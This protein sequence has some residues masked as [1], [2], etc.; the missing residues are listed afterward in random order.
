MSLFPRITVGPVIGRV[1]STSVRLLVETDTAAA[2]ARCVVVYNGRV[3]DQQRIHTAHTH[4]LMKHTANENG[5]YN[6]SEWGTDSAMKQQ[7]QSSSS[8]SS[9]YSEIGDRESHPHDNVPPGTVVQTLRLRIVE[10]GVPFAFTVRHL[11]PHSLYTLHIHT[12]N[13]MVVV[14]EEKPPTGRRIGNAHHHHRTATIHTYARLGGEDD[15]YLD[16]DS[17]SLS[18]AVRSAIGNN[19][20]SDRSELH[21]GDGGAMMRIVAV[22]G[23]NVR[24]RQNTDLWQ[25]LAEM[26]GAIP[27]TEDGTEADG[28]TGSQRKRQRRVDLV[29]HLGSQVFTD[30]AFAVARRLLRAHEEDC[31]QGNDDDDDDEASE[32]MEHEITE[33]FRDL[34]RTA[35]SYGPLQRVLSCA[36]HLMLL[37]EGELRSFWAENPEDMDPR[38]H[39]FYIATIA[40]RVYTEYQ[41]QLWDDTPLEQFQDHF[42]RHEGSHHHLLAGRR[43]SRIGLL[44]LDQLVGRSFCQQQRSNSEYLSEQQWQDMRRLLGPRGTFRDTDVL[45]VATSSPVV[46]LQQNRGVVL[47]EIERH[48]EVRCNW[49]FSFFREEQM[50]FLKLLERWKR[51]KNTRKEMVN[52]HVLLLCGSLGCGGMVDIKRNGRSLCR[53]VLVGPVTNTPSPWASSRVVRRLSNMELILSVDERDTYTSHSRDFC[54]ERNLCLVD[55]TADGPSNEMALPLRGPAEVDS[56]EEEED[57]TVRDVLGE[58]I[59]TVST[60]IVKA[61][62]NALVTEALQDGDR[63]NDMIESS[64]SRSSSGRSDRGGYSYVADENYDYDYDDGAGMSL[65]GV[66]TP[67]RK[68]RT[69]SNIGDSMPT[70]SPR[71]INRS[72]RFMSLGPRSRHAANALASRDSK[73]QS[74]GVIDRAVTFDQ[75][76]HHERLAEEMEMA[77]RRRTIRMSMAAVSKD[78]FDSGR[79]HDSVNLLMQQQQHQQKVAPKLS[80]RADKKGEYSSAFTEPLEEDEEDE[81]SD[82]E[83]EPLDARERQTYKTVAHMRRMEGV[84]FGMLF[85]SALAMVMLCVLFGY[86]VPDALQYTRES[87]LHPSRIVTVSCLIFPFMIL[88]LSLLLMVRSCVRESRHR[89][90]RNKATWYK[91]RSGKKR[92]W[93]L[94]RKLRKR[95]RCFDLCFCFSLF[96]C[97]VVTAIQITAVLALVAIYTVLALAP[98]SA[99]WIPPLQSL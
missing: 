2:H 7:R 27:S 37:G 51:L 68:R 12:S 4:V 84:L 81:G 55:I 90:Q 72:K 66:D 93:R 57:D 38:S 95:Q 39:D 54:R 18:S 45:I 31:S 78:P 91:K 41:K 20:I 92:R 58:V 99:P 75:L 24:R 69:V 80:G 42:F 77:E 13:K 28:G 67:R 62:R 79:H 43:G 40:R 87:L 46:F 5:N 94:Q 1:T 26:M 86:F 21:M 88:L 63:E 10:G 32:R 60:Q 3:A 53:Q 56:E 71:K 64:R 30:E 25:E 49:A 29:L 52:R 8:S 11:R 9:D 85:L 50:A 48:G 17:L 35:W 73:H 15:G 19:G 74:R 61:K 16:F 98:D 33:L 23:D 6:N 96:G 36:S 70:I 22:S 89:S 65:D 14:V 83:E 34:Y 97:F 47:S 82:I 76:N 44:A 59:V